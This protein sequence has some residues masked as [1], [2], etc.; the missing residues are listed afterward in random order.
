M[1]PILV[2][3]LL[4]LLSAVVHLAIFCITMQIRFFAASTSVQRGNDAKTRNIRQRRGGNDLI[5]THHSFLN[6]VDNPR[7]QSLLLDIF[8]KVSSLPYGLIY[9]QKS[10]VS[11]CSMLTVV[12]TALTF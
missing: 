10:S 8:G 1:L 4:L 5:G 6:P 9:T 12:V 7:M 3:L 2:L 11:E